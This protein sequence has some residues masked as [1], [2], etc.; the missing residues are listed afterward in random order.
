LATEVLALLRLRPRRD[1]HLGDE[2]ALVQQAQDRVLAGVTDQHPLA[3]V[4]QGVAALRVAV[5]HLPHGRGH[6]EALGARAQAPVGPAAGK[7][8]G[9]RGDRGSGWLI[10]RRVMLTVVSVF[11]A[12]LAGPASRWSFCFH[13]SF[14]NRPAFVSNSPVASTWTR[15]IAPISTPAVLPFREK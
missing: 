11:D 4:Q 3:A 10:G 1:G 8:R 15:A 14:T 12:G 6:L 13:S 9:G 5:L 7:E 2:L